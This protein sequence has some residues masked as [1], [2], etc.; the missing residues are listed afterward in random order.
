M[1]LPRVL[2]ENKIEECFNKPF[3]KYNNGPLS[4]WRAKDG[5]SSIKH[6]AR[7]TLGITATSSPSERVFS[8]VT[9]FHCPEDHS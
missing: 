1:K 4:Y 5:S 8:I 9:N 3:L 6:L 2:V 7:D